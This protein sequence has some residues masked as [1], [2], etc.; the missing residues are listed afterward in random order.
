MWLEC[1][2]AGKTVGDEEAR[3]R[4]IDLSDVSL[5]KGVTSCF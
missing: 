4:G 2:E 5:V 1:S 3:V